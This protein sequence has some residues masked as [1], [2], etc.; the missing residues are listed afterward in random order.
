MKD[1]E[2]IVDAIM[3]DSRFQTAVANI[4]HVFVENMVA[5]QTECPEQNEH[6]EQ[7]VAPAAGTNKRP[8][9]TIANIADWT[10]KLQ[11]YQYKRTGRE[12]PDDLNDEL[13]RRFPTYDATKRAFVGNRRPKGAKHPAIVA[14]AATHKKPIKELLTSSLRSLYYKI[15]AQG[16]KIPDDL[17]DELARRC[18]EYDPVTRAFSKKV[19]NRKKASDKSDTALK[20][21][22]PTPAM[23][24]TKQPAYPAPAK[25]T[26]RP[27][28]AVAPKFSHKV[29]WSTQ[30]DSVL[31]Q[32]YEFHHTRGREI[33]AELNAVLA[34]RFPEYDPISQ[35]FAQKNR[36]T[37]KKNLTPVTPI[38]SS[39]LHVEIKPLKT[40]LTN[41]FNDV[42]IN[43]TRVLHNHADTELQTFA[44]GTIL[45]VHGIVTDNADLP[46][47]PLWMLYNTRMTPINWPSHD[48]Y[49]GYRV[50]AKSV[51]PTGNEVRVQ[52]SNKAFLFLNAE[53]QKM[54][55][56]GVLF[57]I[58]NTKQ[59]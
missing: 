28:P 36:N 45:G 56:P 58:A 1:I 19:N 33:D 15:R 21:E 7:T 30:G 44:D 10:L 32:V 14:M 38:V 48:K 54:L 9:K 12:I 25:Q 24:P 13:A 34:E 2:K 26:N 5:Q 16:D 18:P 39:T 52:M 41:V 29:N 4:L 3:R 6:S 43:G 23:T 40:T 51:F 53:K 42:Y 46:Q 17:N 57:E 49:S 11:F 8:K 50:Y 55:N 20:P 31:R 59:K 27:A 22:N 37:V 47:R 35:K